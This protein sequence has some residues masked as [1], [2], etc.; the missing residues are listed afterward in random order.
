MASSTRAHALE[1]W[2][3]TDY[4]T[5]GSQVRRDD[6]VRLLDSISDRR[7][8]GSGLGGDGRLFRFVEEDD[9]VLCL[10]CGRHDVCF[11]VSVQVGDFYIFHSDLSG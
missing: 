11:A 10:T 9:E 4:G 1:V 2:P 3:G 5:A 7:R 6:C 8:R